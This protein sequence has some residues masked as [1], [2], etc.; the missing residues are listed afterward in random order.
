MTKRRFLIFLLIS[1]AGFFVWP[2]IALADIQLSNYEANLFL[3]SI[4]KQPLFGKYIDLPEPNEQIVIILIRKAI[5][6]KEL[7]YILIDVPKEYLIKLFKLGAKLL[8]SENVPLVILDEI[9][10]KSVEKAV[11]IATNWL[12]QNEI[13]VAAGTLNYSFKSYKGNQQNPVFYYNLAYRSLIDKSGELSIEFYSPDPFEPPP[14]KGSSTMQGTYWEIESWRAAGNEKLKPFIIK[15]KGRVSKEK[16]GGYIWD[17]A[18]VEITFS[19]KVP[20]WKPSEKKEPVTVLDKIQQGAEKFKQVVQKIQEIYS[21]IKDIFPEVKLLG[22]QIASLETKTLIPAEIL[23]PLT[24]QEAEGIISKIEEVL[25]KEEETKEEEKEI[26]AEAG[27]PPPPPE[28]QPPDLEEIQEILDDISE[29]VDIVNQEVIEIVQASGGEVTLEGP[30]PEILV[31]APIESDSEEVEEIEQAE[32][33]PEPEIEPPP[34]EPILASFSPNTTLP[35]IL[36]SEVCA[37][38]GSAGNEFIEL[39]NPN[40]QGVSL[41]KYNFKLKLVSSGGKVTEKRIDELPKTIPTKGYFLLVGGEISGIIVDATFSDQLSSAGGV[42][43]T[44][45]GDNIKDRV[46]WGKP[47]KNPPIEA[48]ETTGIILEDGLKTNKSLERIK[49]DSNLFDTDN[50][51]QDF[52]LNNNPSPTNSS[53]YTRLYDSTPPETVLDTTPQNLSESTDADFTFHSNEENSIFDCKIDE[54]GWGG[55]VS[56]KKYSGLSEGAH[57]FQVRATDLV[58]NTNPTPVIFSWTIQVPQPVPSE[59]PPS[60]EPPSEPPPPPEPADY[61]LINEIQIEGANTTDDWVE[62]Y[63]PTDEEVDI[64]QWSIQKQSVGG[65][66]F[67]KKNFRT[68]DKVPSKGYFLIVRN[69]ADENLK[70]IADMTCSALQLSSNNT[71]YLV[72]NK[73]A[74]ENGDDPNIVDKV[75]FGES[76]FSPE[77][78]A[79]PEPPAEKSTQRKTLGIDTNDNSQ[80]FVINETPS[81]TNSKGEAG[82]TVLTNFQIAEDT[83]FSLSGSPYIVQNNLTVDEGKTLT[84]E[85]G[86]T[87]KFGP[88]NSLIVNGVLKAIGQENKKITFTR[89]AEDGLWQG[90]YFSQTSNNSELNWVKVEYAET[91]PWQYGTTASILVDN[92]S[93]TFKNST[94]ENYPF[95]G[96]RLINSSNSLIENSNF[97][98]QN[99][100]ESN[101]KGIEIWDGTPTVKNSFF[102]NHYYGIF[103]DA[104]TIGKPLVENNNFEENNYPIWSIPQTIFKSN[105]GQ[106]NTYDGIFL[107]GYINNENLTLF[108]N[109]LPYVIQNTLEVFE[110]K[111]LTIEP[112]TTVK[113]DGNVKLKVK[114]QLIAQGT[115]P[116]NIITFVPLVPSTGYRDGIQFFPESQNSI[117]ENVVIENC[118]YYIS[119]EGW[120]AAIQ[121]DNTQVIFDNLTLRNSGRVGLFAKNSDSIIRNSHFTNNQIG[122][123]IEGDIY[124]QITNCQIE[125]NDWNIVWNSGG[126]NCQNF[127]QEYPGVFCDCCQ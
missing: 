62:L 84:I 88:S 17:N 86:T 16:E 99:K 54:E 65:I 107:S 27:P 109:S 50:N 37:G 30:T 85:A 116:E 53:G 97:F 90:I 63:N 22:G 121:I 24:I 75:G 59:E 77:G 71:V 1:L 8:V 41:D 38:W 48:V 98:G 3:D 111:V 49:I 43:I 66:A 103:I 56:P 119:G 68:D 47:D 61:I 55:C 96:L 60:E 23:E 106:N 104:L 15:I 51:S 52:T 82:P 124:P 19:E 118:G 101:S 36:I 100:T 46:S 102:K 35:K 125:S 127:Q 40:D 25:N 67:D 112:G 57:Q 123:R 105:Q 11:E 13:K 21:W 72:N 79:A 12:Q 42:I 2:K 110:G 114:G 32:I 14:S 26:P 80:D 78:T 39:Y 20:E 58:G 89:L 91:D 5:Q 31:Q 28:S 64:S 74:I 115:L 126:E 7:R 122:I 29:M 73:E 34:P 10:K 76:P 81:P 117:L 83:T 113:F 18:N 70:M 9:E 108:K 92:S 94:V 120:E 44:D 87:L 69:D 95:R 93:I 33:E 45:G 6:Q 4:Q